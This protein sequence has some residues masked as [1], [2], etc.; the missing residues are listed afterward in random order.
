MNQLYIEK[1][2]F[3]FF[4]R[5]LA[6]C[7]FYLF[8][9]FFFVEMGGSK[10]GGRASKDGWKGRNGGKWQPFKVRNED[11]GG[12]SRGSTEYSSPADA[13]TGGI[14]RGHPSQNA[15]AS[16]YDPDDDEDYYAG[17]EPDYHYQHYHSGQQYYSH[18]KPR[19]Y[20]DPAAL[21]RG[22]L[23]LH[24]QFVLR[25]DIPRLL[26][27][28]YSNT[29]YT[30][31]I[32]ATAGSLGSIGVVLGGGEEDATSSLKEQVSIPGSASAASTGPSSY[33][34]MSQGERRLLEVVRS[35]DA[36]VPWEAVH[37]VV[38][39]SELDDFECPICLEPPI[40]PRITECGH[41]YCLPCILHLIRDMKEQDRNRTC[42]VCHA[43]ISAH[44]LRPALLYPTNAFNKKNN[45]ENP[46]VVRFDLFRREK[47]SCLLRRYD[48][49]FHELG[50]AVRW[51]LMSSTGQKTNPNQGKEDEGTVET[52]DTTTNAKGEKKHTRLP[53][54]GVNLPALEGP[55]YELR[56]PR[57]QEPWSTHS[58]YL[59]STA[60][61]EETQLCIDS[62]TISERL[63]E[64]GSTKQVNSGILNG[65]GN[66]ASP[67]RSPAEAL[68]EQFLVA[69]LAEVTKKTAPLPQS[70]A[71][72]SPLIGATRPPPPSAST[73][74]GAAAYVEVYAESQ[75]LPYYLHM[76]NMQMLR[77][78]APLRGQTRLPNSVSGRILEIQ[79]LE[80]TNETRK[81]YKAFAHVPMHTSIQLCVLDLS[82]VVLPET[83]HHF[84]PQLDAM[85]KQRNQ[86]R[87]R[88]ENHAR[89]SHADQKWEEYKARHQGNTT[90]YTNRLNNS[91][92]NTPEMRPLPPPGSEDYERQY[93]ALKGSSVYSSSSSQLQHGNPYSL[94]SFYVPPQTSSGGTSPEMRALSEPYSLDV[95]SS[96]AG[97][98]A[99]GEMPFLQLPSACSVGSDHGLPPNPLETRQR[100]TKSNLLTSIGGAGGGGAAGVG[101]GNAGGLS[102]TSLQQHVQTSCWSS[103]NSKALLFQNQSNPPPPL[104]DANT[105]SGKLLH[106][107]RE[108]EEEEGEEDPSVSYSSSALPNTS[109]FTITSTSKWKTTVLGG[110][111]GEAGTRNAMHV[112]P[113]DVSP[114]AEWLARERLR[115]EENGVEDPGRGNLPTSHISRGARKGEEHK[116]SA[117]TG[118][119]KNTHSG[120]EE[121]S[122]NNESETAGNRRRHKKK[123]NEWI[124][125]TSKSTGKHK[126]RG[127]HKALDSDDDFDD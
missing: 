3:S 4:V 86:R 41:V 109:N 74:T 58:R 2:F 32:S 77:H 61:F 5:F 97:G 27:Q 8:I 7:C 103:G 38:V 66:V 73:S 42:P 113:E 28:Y 104:S 117:V 102:K 39:R 111:K 98:G 64:L 107:R 105:W 57:V 87:R 36:M 94:H 125:T 118:T 10:G 119:N 91:Q 84:K 20:V 68:E 71:K 121:S 92:N 112:D 23:L 11:D 56:L 96:T 43:R 85:A 63:E 62:A 30:S 127:N 24:F 47:G 60:E 17:G 51:S 59:Y 70:L 114:H 90:E 88:E 115:V 83:L 100:A 1:K 13:P 93:P 101:T 26:H 126:Q 95:E 37:A 14:G 50:D 19:R 33:R 45:A 82:G 80:Q 122:N 46:P 78:D 53:N 49:P 22:F 110:G 44:A 67:L 124:E 123:K 69:A 25:K 81:I 120:P 65:Q 29:P 52:Q 18:H 15:F 108:E 79:T 35:S 9:I 16:H 21:R 99:P 89:Q 76:I 106:A 75:G 72:V 31:P 34:R 40:A 55:E 54:A 12:F 48:D 6:L 116:A